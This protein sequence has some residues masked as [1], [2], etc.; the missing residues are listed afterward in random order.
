MGIL[1][2]IKK[3][4]QKKE[5]DFL[6]QA[7]QAE[8]QGDFQL[9]IENYEK[10][11]LTIF[12]DKTPDKYIHLTKKIINCYTQIGDFEKVINLW[13][14][15]YKVGE[16]TAK[17]KYE[18]I[19][20]LENAG[21]PDLALNIFNEA[22]NTLLANK[23][24]FLIRQKKIPEANHELSNLIASLPENHPKYYDLIIKKA[25]LSMSLL[26]WDEAKRYLNKILEKNPSHEEAKKLR[27][28]CAKQD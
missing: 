18:L 23:I 6:L 10:I 27:A 20:V 13:P 26:K 17:E 16:Y 5:E 12:E 25:K 7:E 19:K 22:G 15:Q 11:I 9:A 24:E 4:F 21:K 2:F 3:P 1:N 28:F 8:K 14:T